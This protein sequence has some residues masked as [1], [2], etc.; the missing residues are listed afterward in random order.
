MKAE[1][2]NQKVEEPDVEMKDQPETIHPPKLTTGITKYFQ[3]ATEE[4]RNRI[5][6]KERQQILK[7]QQAKTNVD[8]ETPQKTETTIPKGVSEEKNGKYTYSVRLGV[9]WKFPAYSNLNIS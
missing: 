3:P 8:L 7:K 9:K 4:D 5:L 1:V 6:E 2:A